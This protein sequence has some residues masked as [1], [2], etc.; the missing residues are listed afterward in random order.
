MRG[1]LGMCLVLTGCV[2]SDLQDGRTLYRQNCATCHGQAGQGDGPQA[3]QLAI[4]PADLTGLAARNA[5]TFP[6]EQVIATVYGYRG[7]DL[8]GL[9]PA[10]GE[11]LSGPVVPWTSPEGEV[12]ETPKALLDLVDYLK[13]LQTR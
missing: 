1:L 6:T 12:L 5:G 2:V 8:A 3:A 10:F 4:A 13:T 7:K 9:M 11:V